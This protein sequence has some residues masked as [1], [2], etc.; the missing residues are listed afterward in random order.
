MQ[1]ETMNEAVKEGEARRTV[2]VTTDHGSRDTITTTVVD[3][4]DR[5][6]RTRTSVLAL[7]P[8]GQWVTESATEKWSRGGWT[9]AN[10]VDLTNAVNGG[11]LSLPQAGLLRIPYRPTV[12]SPDGTELT[13]VDAVHG[14]DGV[15]MV[16][17]D[18]PSRQAVALARR[19]NGAQQ[20]YAV[21][22]D[23][24][25]VHLCAADG[26]G[27]LYIPVEGLSDL[28]EEV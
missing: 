12:T 11:C 15:L 1:T 5:Y 14:P 22:N 23:G 8:D 19:T 6:A 21:S 2:T 3:V 10:P 28:A 13:T 24:E 16:T 20:W 17:D 4:L 25:V 18:R 26:I 7:G 27:H 9:S